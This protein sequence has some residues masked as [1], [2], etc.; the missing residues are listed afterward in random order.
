MKSP[1]HSE[2]ISKLA[3]AVANS[4]NANGEARIKNSE[5]S[6][7]EVLRW[8]NHLQKSEITGCCDEML[9]GIRAAV[10]EATGGI[11]L[12]L[13][14]LAIFAMRGQIDLALAWLFFK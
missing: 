3:A 1:V 13:V 11:A 10:I 12:G 8:I 4:V 7:T 2:Q 5:I 14:R 6:V 9:L